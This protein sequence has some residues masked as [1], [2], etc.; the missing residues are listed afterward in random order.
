MNRVMPD[1]SGF[2]GRTWCAVDANDPALNRQVR[3]S[4]PW[5]RTIENRPLRA[6]S[7]RSTCLGLPGAS[8]R[9][10]PA[11]PYR[12]RRPAY[13]PEEGQDGRPGHGEDR[14]PAASFHGQ[15]F[16][17]R[18]SRVGRGEQADP[19]ARNLRHQPRGAGLDREA[20]LP[21]GGADLRGLG[22]PAGGVGRTR[23]LLPPHHGSPTPG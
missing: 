17:A 14:S 1:E 2:P 15:R 3:G 20:A 12:L 23:P 16:L 5:R 13:V 8:C 10:P 9:S 7:R 21:D 6:G 22:D 18:R 4:S 19:S 11:V